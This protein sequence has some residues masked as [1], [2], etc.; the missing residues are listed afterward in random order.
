MH[1]KFLRRRYDL[2]EDVKLGELGRFLFGAKGVA[3]RRFRDVL[4]ARIFIK[5]LRAA[6]YQLLYAI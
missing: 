5:N 1:R 6:H 4:S 3:L 2:C